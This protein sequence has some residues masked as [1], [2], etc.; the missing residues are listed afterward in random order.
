MI[1][2]ADTA[3]WSQLFVKYQILNIG[4]VSFLL[5]GY[6]KVYVSVKIDLC[7][8]LTCTD[9]CLNYYHLFIHSQKINNNAV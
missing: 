7:F 4:F 8:E 6:V 3:I 1:L 5:K 9:M 2:S